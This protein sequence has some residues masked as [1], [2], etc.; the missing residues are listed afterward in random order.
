MSQRA[1]FCSHL[2]G[3]D[4][5]QQDLAAALLWFYNETGLHVDRTAPELANDLHE[6]GFSRPN[7]THLKQK[8]AA[9]K[10]TIKGTRKNS[11]K[12]GLP[13]HTY[14][15]GEY[16]GFLKKKNIP[17]SSSILPA[18]WFASIGR[19]YLSNLCQQING[20]YDCGFFDC[21]AVMCRRLM[22][23][24]IIEVY[25]ASSRV[26]EIEEGKNKFKPLEQL[27]KIISSD[28]QV[29]LN[30][31]TPGVLN[32]VKKLGDTAAHHRTHETD[33]IEIDEVKDDYRRIIQEL[34]VLAGLRK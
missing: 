32:K 18:E 11:F 8:L 7:V 2:S 29:H 15:T 9:H 20:S 1:V 28:K 34:L 6:E 33:P 16:G 19:K 21:C 27:I 24:L 5:N 17:V 26:S 31:N 25:V 23:T 30:R 3:L 10:K 14:F 13:H 4:L 12:I 22:E